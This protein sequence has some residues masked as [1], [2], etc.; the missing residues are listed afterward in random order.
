MDLVLVFTYLERICFESFSILD[1]MFKYVIKF[2]G[3]LYL[4]KDFIH[5]V[6][7]YKKSIKV[8]CTS[9]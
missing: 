3:D 6:E 5:V 2:V 4:K 1:K 8:D 7:S 9:N